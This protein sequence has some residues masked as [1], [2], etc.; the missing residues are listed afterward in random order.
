MA[1]RLFGRGR[2][3]GMLRTALDRPGGGVVTLFGLPGGG[4]SELALAAVADVPHVYH[5]VPPLPEPEQRAA[6]R[7]AMDRLDGGW[8]IRADEPS[9]SAP[10]R[11]GAWSGGDAWSE[12][13]RAASTAVP[14]GRGAVLV[15]DDAHRLEPAR[16]RVLAA[17]TDALKAAR[18]RG[19][20]LHVILVAPSDFVAADGEGWDVPPERVRLAPLGF[21]AA[22]PLLPGSTANERLEAYAVFGG[23][24]A[25]LALLDRGLSLA[26]NLRRLV[27]R[28]TGPLADAG[29]DLL[30][31]AAQ[32]PARYAAILTALSGGESDWAGVH[33]GVADLTASGQVAPYLKRLEELGLVAVRRSLDASARSRNR[34]YGITD[35]FF[36]FWFR[37]VLPHREEL[38][39]AKGA[40]V[41]LERLRAELGR[42]VA[43]VLPEVCRQYMRQDALETLGANA[44]ECGGLWGAGYDIPVAG[45]LSSGAAFYGRPALWREGEPPVLGT[46]DREIRETRYGFGRERRLRL[47]FV[48]GEAPLP[49]AREVARRHDVTVVDVRALAGEG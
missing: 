27:L 21:R 29:I 22:T 42:Q 17:L 23:L 41:V 25:H 35:P 1:P 6:L 24:P 39:L 26:K 3:L 38:A 2:E 5:R 8:R 49:L 32:A 19:R 16:A 40:D 28:A 10:A 45:I 46:L 9:P 18:A 36:A 47:L 31:R 14:E 15:L 7:R 33:A 44:R 20:S 43:T 12:L 30:E 48:R 4:K 13:F 11:P 37:F 34:R